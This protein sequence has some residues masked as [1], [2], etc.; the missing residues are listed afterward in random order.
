[1]SCRPDRRAETVPMSTCPDAAV[2]DVSK[3]L[4]SAA[5]C[6]VKCGAGDEAAVHGT[7]HVGG[8]NALKASSSSQEPSELRVKFKHP[9]GR[10][11]LLG[12]PSPAW[13]PIC[14]G[15][16]REGPGRQERHDFARTLVL[17][18]AL[19]RV[20]WA[21]WGGVSLG[22]H[23]SEEEAR[24]RAARLGS[25]R[26]TSDAAGCASPGIRRGARPCAAP[27]QWHARGGDPATQLARAR[28]VI[29][30]QE[31]PRARPGP[32]AVPAGRSSGLG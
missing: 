3:L 5:S 21:S 15:Q 10:A 7:S 26:A 23:A 12:T 18:L 27:A 22:V 13:A 31:G 6:C 25:L 19:C 17:A 11:A 2:G 8:R 14:P 9:T 4:P 28:R 24:G 1:M 29:R 32:S 16:L 20:P 30:V